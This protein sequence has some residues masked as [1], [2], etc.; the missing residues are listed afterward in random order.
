LRWV[1][2]TD[3]VLV[4]VLVYTQ[5]PAGKAFSAEV[6]LADLKAGKLK[7]V[8]SGAA[9]AVTRDGQVAAFMSRAGVRVGP[10]ATWKGEVVPEKPLETAD[11]L[12][13]GSGRFLIAGGSKKGVPT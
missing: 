12:F 2:G 6:R 4:N 7:T 13:S 9:L 3:T 10:T 11:F 8:T 5:T 1:P